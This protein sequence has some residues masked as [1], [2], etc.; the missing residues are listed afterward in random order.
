VKEFK[1]NVVS[2]TGE[3]VKFYKLSIAADR[4][5]KKSDMKQLKKQSKFIRNIN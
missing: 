4:I 2:T 1:K 3:K 5:K